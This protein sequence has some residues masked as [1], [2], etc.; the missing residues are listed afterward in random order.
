MHI[1]PR[2]SCLLQMYSVKFHST[3]RAI[4]TYFQ[5]IEYLVSYVPH[6]GGRKN[7]LQPLDLQEKDEYDD[8]GSTNLVV[9]LIRVTRKNALHNLDK[10]NLDSLFYCLFSVNKYNIQEFPLKVW[11]KDSWL[12][13]ILFNSS[14]TPRRSNGVRFSFYC[15][16]FSPRYK[17]RADIKISFYFLFMCIFVFQVW[18]LKQYKLKAKNIKK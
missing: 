18:N 4:S 11:G 15:P 14:L 16:C 7:L 9:Y 3:P 12:V 17:Y 6:L 5:I 8:I 13:R 10:S 1:R 2:G